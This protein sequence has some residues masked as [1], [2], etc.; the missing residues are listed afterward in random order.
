MLFRTIFI[1][2]YG[3]LSL[4]CFS[5]G[6]VTYNPKMKVNIKFLNNCNYN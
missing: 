6:R 2:D 3:S 1:A 5:E 4:L